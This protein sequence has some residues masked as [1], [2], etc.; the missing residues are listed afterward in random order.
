MSVC[1]RNKHTS[2]LCLK[3]NYKPGKT[4]LQTLFLYAHFIILACCFEYVGISK[5]VRILARTQH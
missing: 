2:I 4:F 3:M 1:F 5:L